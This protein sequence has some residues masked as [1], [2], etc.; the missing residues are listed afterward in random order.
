MTSQK[1]DTVY[2]EK[3]NQIV[4]FYKDVQISKEYTKLGYFD[5]GD[6]FVS[7][8]ENNPILESW[9]NKIIVI[10]ANVE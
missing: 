7:V 8:V 1:A 3:E 10:S 5:A 2:F 9:G 4:L 6:D